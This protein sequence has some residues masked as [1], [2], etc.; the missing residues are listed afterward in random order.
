[1]L[2]ETLNFDIIHFYYFKQHLQ[3]LNFTGEIIEKKTVTKK[4]ML[5]YVSLDCPANQQVWR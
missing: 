1:M 2:S 3:T 5:L 4:E